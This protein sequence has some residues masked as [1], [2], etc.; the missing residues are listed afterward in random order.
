MQ[1]QHVAGAVGAADERGDDERREH[2]QKTS[3]R[4]RQREAE[5]LQ[6]ERQHLAG[7][8]T[9]ASRHRRVGHTQTRNI[10]TRPHPCRRVLHDDAERERGEAQCRAGPADARED[11]GAGERHAHAQERGVV[12]LRAVVARE[13]HDHRHVAEKERAVHNRAVEEREPGRLGQVGRK[14]E[15]AAEHPVGERRQRH[16]ALY[17]QQGGHH[18][19]VQPPERDVAVPGAGEDESGRDEAAAEGA[20]HEHHHLALAE[21]G[22]RVHAVRSVRHDAGHKRIGKRLRERL[23]QQRE[24]EARDAPDAEARLVAAAHVRSQLMSGK[25]RGTLP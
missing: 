7:R 8:G 23:Q 9:V 15:E 4:Q 20:D 6:R 18:Q 11:H 22:E 1:G 19:R 21:R 17:G 10:G 14:R 3:K 5:L 13:E 12:G 16:R 25:A 24:V 2:E